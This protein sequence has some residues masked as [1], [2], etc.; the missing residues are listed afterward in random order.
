M[1][2]MSGIVVAESDP[3]P[4]RD[5]ITPKMVSAG[6]DVLSEYWVELTTSECSIAVFPEVVSAIYSA[7]EN[8]RKTSS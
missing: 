1:A 8:I 3:S 2:A 5:G 4:D 6:N 7:M